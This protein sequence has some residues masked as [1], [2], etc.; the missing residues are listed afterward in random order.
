MNISAKRHRDQV[1]GTNH[2]EQVTNEQKSRNTLTEV[3]EELADNYGYGQKADLSD[4][5]DEDE[6]NNYDILDS[7]DYYF[8]VSLAEDTPDNADLRVKL[9]AVQGF[10]AFQSNKSEFDKGLHTYIS[11]M[12]KSFP[13]LEVVT[14]HK[15]EIWATF[16]MS[17]KLFKQ[18]LEYKKDRFGY[19]NKIRKMKNGDWIAK[20][21]KETFGYKD[22]STFIRFF[23]EEPIRLDSLFVLEL[24]NNNDV[25][26][27]G[28]GR[29]F[30]IYMTMNHPRRWAI[31]M[32]YFRKLERNVQMFPCF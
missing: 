14:Q 17:F 26:L 28:C 5:H 32:I 18:Y 22:H 23:R 19:M 25:V 15:K 6:D 4:T 16:Q 12:L 31:M 27:I 20:F 11:G 24:L 1:M 21:P 9:Q 29:L 2:D 10:Q 3:Q 7:I 8:L 30:C 13:T